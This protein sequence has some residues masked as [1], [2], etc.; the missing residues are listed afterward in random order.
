MLACWLSVV[1]GAMRV[2]GEIETRSVGGGREVG[3]IFVGWERREV[4]FCWGWS[5]AG[6]LARRREVLRRRGVVSI[7]RRRG[8]VGDEG[9]M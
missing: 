4:E 7:L 8:A 1:L 3:W 6:S 9:R 5:W 2:S